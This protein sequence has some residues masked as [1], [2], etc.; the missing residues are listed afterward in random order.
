MPHRVDTATSQ[1]L[2]N[3]L[4]MAQQVDAT[5]GCLTGCL[6][7]CLIGCLTGLL[8]TSLAVSMPHCMS[9]WLSHHLTGCLTPTQPDA[10]KL[11]AAR[12]Q[13]PLLRLLAD[14]S[15]EE[16]LEA[17]NPA[18]LEDLHIWPQITDFDAVQLDSTD[19]I[20]SV[21]CCVLWCASSCV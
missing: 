20:V 18:S 7:V 15:L 12:E 9:H 11:S 14:D 10:P 4:E 17:S 13:L 2:H 3:S 16:L 6:T 5:T 8:T 1:F 21:R 19:C